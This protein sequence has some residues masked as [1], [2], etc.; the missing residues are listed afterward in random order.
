MTPQTKDEDF[1]NRFYSVPVHFHDKCG[2][3]FVPMSVV[4]YLLD[5]RVLLLMDAPG[6]M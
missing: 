3:L 6:L 4:C 1:L 5:C 2:P